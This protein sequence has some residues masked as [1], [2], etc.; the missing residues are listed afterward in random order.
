LKSLVD[1]AD[2]VK[3]L[4]SVVNAAREGFDDQA[5][6][7]HV[8]N[9][10]TSQWDSQINQEPVANAEVPES[11]PQTT[12]EWMKSAPPEIQS[13]VRNAM[14]IENQEKAT[15]V[16]KM[17]ANLSGE[18]K[19]RLIQVLSEKSLDELRTLSPL[20]PEEEQEQEEQVEPATSSVANYFGASAPETNQAESNDDLL[21]LPSMSF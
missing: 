3:S 6:N 4:E 21:P 16:E 13:A 14:D 17:T 19:D 12:E 1:N 9:E 5:G 10:T 18:N 20:A 7:S 15:L 11:V 8:F 2:Q